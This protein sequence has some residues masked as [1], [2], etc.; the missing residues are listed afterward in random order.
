M[1]LTPYLSLAAC[2]LIGAQGALLAAPK[3]RLAATTVGPVSIPAGSNGTAQEVEVYND[4]DGSLSVSASS[5]AAWA[6]TSVLGERR[7]SNRAGNCIPVRIGLNTASLAAGRHATTV[8]VTSQGA[9][10]GTQNI[11]VIV[12]MGGGVPDALNL[13]V[14]PSGGA[15]ATD[16]AEVVTLS[17]GTTAA[18]TQTGGNWLSVAVQG[19][20]F[21]FNIPYQ[22]KATYQSG[23]A[24]GTYT[25]AVQFD[26]STLAS[27]NKRVAVTLRV[28]SQPIARPSSASLRFRTPL[29]TP[30]QLQRVVIN[31]VSGGTLTLGTITAATVAGGNWLTAAQIPGFNIVDITADPTGVQAGVYKGSVTIASNAANGNVV[32]PVEIEVFAAGAPVLPPDSVLNNATFEPGE[33]VAQGGIVAIKGEQLHFGDPQQ[34]SSLPLPTTLGETRVFVNNQPAGLY[35]VSYGQINF[36][37]P[38]E[39]ATGE[40][41][42]RVE[43]SGRASANTTVRVVAKKPKILQLLDGGDQAFYAIAQNASRNNSFPIPARFGIPNS[44]PARVGDTLVIYAL[45]AGPTNPPVASGA[46]APSGPLAQATGNWRVIFGNGVFTSGTEVVPSFVGLVP[47]FVGLYQINV[48]VPANVTKGDLVSFYVQ[49]D[50]VGSQQV[51]VAIQ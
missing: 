39:T 19:G 28:T 37:M 18:T 12:Q 44:E 40:A 34:N 38:F 26:G 46:A 4:G 9:N 33:V 15:G 5:V 45:G 31:N 23:M 41:A 3:L 16:A 27:D 51:F 49:E 48:Q 24:E 30:K 17:R 21:N 8:T 29:T 50:T 14:S 35:Y 43:R 10:E 32:I 6:A 25:G 47:G 1:K 13:Y 2:L 11:L 36:L 42:V 7:C 20:S 22:V